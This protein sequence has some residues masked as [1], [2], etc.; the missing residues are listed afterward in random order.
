MVILCL[1]RGDL[2]P[3]PCFAPDMNH[4]FSYEVQIK[5]LD[6]YRG[7]LYLMMRSLGYVNAIGFNANDMLFV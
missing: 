4:N 5:G 3:L 6:F 1:V 2:P 7:L